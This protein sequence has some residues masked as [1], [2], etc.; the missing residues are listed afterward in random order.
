MSLSENE[1]RFRVA[2]S[3]PGEKRAYVE[4]AAR[5]LAGRFGEDAIPYDR[6]HT[7]EFARPGL[8]SYLPELYHEHAAL[9]VVVLCADYEKKEWCNLEWRAVL[10]LIKKRGDRDIILFHADDADI[11]RK[12][13]PFIRKLTPVVRKPVPNDRKPLP[14]DRKP[15]RTAAPP[16]EAQLRGI[17]VRR[18]SLGTR[19]K[20]GEASAMAGAHFCPASARR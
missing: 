11:V 16:C 17:G 7:A 20:R 4:D 2:F 1:P 13:V 8:G 3:F 9:I 14:N 18:R 6:F 12:P 15:T 10:D 5:L 19:W